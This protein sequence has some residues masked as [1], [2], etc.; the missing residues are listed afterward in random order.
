MSGSKTEY[1]ARRAEEESC[2]AAATAE[3]IVR[4][5]HEN[6][7]AAYAERAGQAKVARM[8]VDDLLT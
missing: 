3:S 8:T 6:F 7:A 2:K 4:Q 1:F 5:T